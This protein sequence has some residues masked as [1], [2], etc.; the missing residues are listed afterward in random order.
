VTKTVYCIQFTAIRREIK[1]D[2][3]GVLGM[4]DPV[5]SKVLSV[6]RLRRLY[7]GTAAVDDVSFDVGRGEI[8]GL[9]GPNGAGKTT[10]INM[11]LGVLE[12]TSGRSASKTPT[13]PRPCPGA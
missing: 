11:I 5:V 13:S 6:N 12:P 3:S 8:V 9:L 4:E 1:Y 10:I 7:G 2:P